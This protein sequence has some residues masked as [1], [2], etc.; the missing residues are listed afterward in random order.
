MIV[1]EEK[2]TVLA[3]L[4]DTLYHLCGGA[5]ERG[6][7]EYIALHTATIILKKEICVVYGIIIGKMHTSSSQTLS[8]TKQELHII[9]NYTTV[10]LH[11][12]C[13]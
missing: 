13:M 12:T 6:Y 7:T 8:Q 10:S 3:L 5:W 9:T 2:S 11:I 4:P 1:Q